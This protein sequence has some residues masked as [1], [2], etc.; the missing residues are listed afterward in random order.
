MKKEMIPTT[1][2]FDK[3]DKRECFFCEVLK[4]AA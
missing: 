4:Y 3:V 1:Y 2:G